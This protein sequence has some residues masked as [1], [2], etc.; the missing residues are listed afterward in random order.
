MA[1][2]GKA[3]KYPQIAEA[4]K[5]HDALRAEECA[6]THINITK[7]NMDKMGWENLMN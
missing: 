4:I 5:A 1:N 2:P 3:E 6:R 7:E